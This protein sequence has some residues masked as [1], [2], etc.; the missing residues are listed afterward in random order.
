MTP[1]P[2]PL[3]GWADGVVEGVLIDEAFVDDGWL[4]AAF[5]QSPADEPA[6]PYKPALAYKPVLA[7]E[8]GLA[9]ELARI[10]SLERTIRWAQAEQF[11]LVEAARVRHAEL[12]GVTGASTSTEREFATRSFVAELATTMVVP[13][14]T[15]GRLVA[16]ATRLAGSRAATLAALAAGEIS[17]AH[18]R[19][20][21]EVT[22]TLPPDAADQIEQVALQDAGSRTSAAFRRRLHRLR[23]RL[24][25]EPLSDRHVRAELER[26]VAVDPAPDGMAWLSLFLSAN[27]A[28][29]IMARLD[30]LA[31]TGDPSRPDPR[32][33]AQRSADI[34]GD[35]LLAG[36]LDTADRHLAAATG[37]VAGKI[38]VTVPVL[39]LGPRPPDTN[40]ALSQNDPSP[41]SADVRADHRR[42]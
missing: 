30:A 34:A 12:E 18:V 20:L 14:P 13:D 32:T 31:D 24:H 4:E 5:A 19:S 28:V 38:V 29:A 26:R 1:T 22:S 33:R 16:D 10:V 37:R 40:C 41:P 17:G 9:A 11:R 15:A 7:D 6:L 2:T 3:L 8:A 42:R 36:T 35:L 39:T 27:R 21:L 25:P 23:E